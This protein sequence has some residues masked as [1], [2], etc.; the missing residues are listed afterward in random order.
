M[1]KKITTISVFIPSEMDAL[2]TAQIAAA[3]IE[4]NQALSDGKRLIAK[5]FTPT[6]DGRFVY[7]SLR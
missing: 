3:F 1:A 5:N 6:T 2:Q 4:F 7:L